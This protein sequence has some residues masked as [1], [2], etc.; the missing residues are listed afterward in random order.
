VVALINRPQLTARPHTVG[1]P[2][3]KKKGGP[4]GGGRGCLPGMPHRQTILM[5]PRR[6]APLRPSAPAGVRCRAKP[7]VLTNIEIIPGETAKGGGGGLG[8]LSR[9]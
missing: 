9:E 4:G 1:L 6:S 2:P 5:E 3:P 7:I 8:V